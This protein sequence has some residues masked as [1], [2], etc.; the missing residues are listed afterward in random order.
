MEVSIKFRTRIEKINRQ[1]ERDYK[2]TLA[3]AQE[4]RNMMNLLEQQTAKKG[5]KGL[6]AAIKQLNG[7]TDCQIMRSKRAWEEYQELGLKCNQHGRHSVDLDM[8][9]EMCKKV[10]KLAEDLLCFSLAHFR[11]VKQKS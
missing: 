11:Q 6:R 4:L 8:L 1:I 7:L 2:R 10:E 3:E 5:V 9:K